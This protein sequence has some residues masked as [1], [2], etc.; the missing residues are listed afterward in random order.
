MMRFLDCFCALVLIILLSPLLVLVVI[1]LSISG[2]REIFYFQNRVG[3]HG[4]E[5]RIIKFATMLK[6]SVNMDGGSVTKA[7][8]PR[9][10]R[11]GAI[12]RRTK[13][14]ELPQLF[15][16]VFGHM[17]LVGPR[18]LVPDTFNR[19]SSN[20]RI[21]ISSIRPG[22]TGYN[23]IVF[24]SEENF[25]GQNVASY[26]SEIL[27]VKERL[28]LLLVEEF[29]LRTYFTILT[30]TVF[31]VFFEKSAIVSQFTSQVLERCAVTNKAFVEDD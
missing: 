2:E 27:P 21:L 4:R 22:V 12:L 8:D 15:N 13:I 28:E 11:V 16:V 7:N 26:Y 5:F 29:C 24:R 31:V 19:Y 18:P 20:A 14:N 9:I 1:L 23:A 17:S 10:T 3:L 30:M 6:D 25:V